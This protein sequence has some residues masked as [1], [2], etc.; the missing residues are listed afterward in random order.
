M[1]LV[2]KWMVMTVNSTYA[3]NNSVPNPTLPV[4]ILC[5]S[6]LIHGSWRRLASK[7]LR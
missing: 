3:V 1:K 6:S 7:W 4:H 2:F 5:T